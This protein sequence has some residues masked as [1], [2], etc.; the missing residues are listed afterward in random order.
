[1]INPT[2]VARAAMRKADRMIA[3]DAPV[4][5][6]LRSHDPNGDGAH[7]YVSVIGSSQDER[8]MPFDY[9]SVR[10]CFYDGA[11]VDELIDRLATRIKPAVHNAL[12]Q[13]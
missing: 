4:E 13:Q 10:A 12:R 8:Q 5:V 7:A 6:R 1:M 9:L 2:N 11:D 3:A